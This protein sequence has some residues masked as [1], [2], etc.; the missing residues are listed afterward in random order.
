MKERGWF[1]WYVPKFIPTTFQEALS[2]YECLLYLDKMVVEINKSFES[3][4]AEL[5]DIVHS[6]AITAVQP[7]IDKINQD[8]ANLVSEF[9]QFKEDVVEENSRLERALEEAVANMQSQFA[10]LV[11]QVD[12]KLT[13]VDAKLSDVDTTLA[14]T[15]KEINSALQNAYSQLTVY[16]NSQIGLIDHKWDVQYALL[17][18]KIDALQF[19]LPDIY[20]PVYGGK[21]SITQTVY[22]LFDN[23]RYGGL[24]ALEFDMLGISAEDFDNVRVTPTRNGMTALEFA[25][26][27]RWILE[28]WSQLHVMFN[29]Y[30][31]ERDTVKDV[32]YQVA[33]MSV[34][35]NLTAQEFDDL[36]V[37]VAYFDAM[38]VTAY[39]FDWSGKT[40]FDETVADQVDVATRWEHNRLIW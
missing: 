29:P 40:I 38:E 2:Y 22:D 11:G 3:L 6:E 28:L 33:T 21:S 1:R 20:N 35:S 23:L 9:N 25:I 27:A 12:D 24:T 5:P 15:I 4:E 16:V 32:L 10:V 30:T 37:D 26:D 31:G 8:F 34:D 7:T 19:D 39:Q 14:D 17:E 18:K 36:S 13:D